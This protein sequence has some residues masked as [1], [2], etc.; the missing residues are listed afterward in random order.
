VLKADY[1]AYSE[2]SER[3]K[4]NERRRRRRSCCTLES[5]QMKSKQKSEM[6]KKH[7]G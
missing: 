1:N 6:I 2:V 7:A 5:V 3:D 4:E